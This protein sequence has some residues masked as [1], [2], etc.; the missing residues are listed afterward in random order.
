M[1]KPVEKSKTVF[2]IALLLIALGLVLNEWLL[3]AM[4]SPDGVVET[5]IRSVIR[6]FEFFLF[7][8][9]SLMLIFRKWIMGN[10]DK[11]VGVGIFVLA[12]IFTLGLSEGAFRL[13]EKSQIL[14]IRLVSRPGRKVGLF[15]YDKHLGWKN[16]ANYE[17]T[18]NLP[19]RTTLEKINKDGWRDEEYDF[20][21]KKGV[22]RIAVL[23]CSFT[24]GL[25]VNAEETYPQRLKAILNESK[26]REF[27]V[28]NFGVNGYGLDQMTINYEKFVRRYDPDLVILQYAWFNSFRA[29]YTS[30]WLTPKPA[31]D[32]EDGK[33]VL[34]NYPVPESSFRPVESWLMDKSLVY[35][36]FKDKIL[37]FTE[38]RKFAGGKNVQFDKKLHDLSTGILARLKQDTE[39]DGTQ[40]TVFVWGKDAKWL[41]KIC[42]NAAVEVF[43]L[44]EYIDSDDWHDVDAITN[45][46]PTGH[47]SPLGHQFVA[48]CHCKVSQANGRPRSSLANL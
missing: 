47:W 15:E 31:L 23:G 45:P 6:I 32:F 11:M 26:H 48:V 29:L 16:R 46:L 17:E 22:F 5:S 20:A 18:Y 10:K 8:T 38:Q 37:I 25:G 41:T 42:Q 21:K 24:Y 12:T 39:N 7:L 1:K 30:M 44:D 13:L 34:K 36:F 14:K 3:V 27:Q 33:L 40:L 2:G 35:R 9:G 43:T 4:F 28:L 19:Y